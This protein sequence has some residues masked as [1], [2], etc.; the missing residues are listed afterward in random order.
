[1]LKL[2]KKSNKLANV[3]SLS[4]IAFQLLFPQY[5][6]AHGPDQTT[7][8]TSTDQSMLAVANLDTPIIF[9][10]AGTPETLPEAGYSTH[11]KKMVVE[12]TA[13]SSTVDQCDGD[14]FTTANGTRVRDGI[15]ATN[16]LP[17]GTRV[18]FPK[19]FGDK[20]FVV[21]DRMNS[22]YTTRMDIWFENRADAI[23]FG[24]KNLEVEIYM[25]K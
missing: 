9:D 17:F 11:Y 21:T 15:I 3:L 16:A 4:I 18:K 6:Y 20:I 19:T 2:A 7:D 13:Y 8:A 24:I 5:S 12:V 23:K 14:P 10:P 22:R 25:Y 1:M